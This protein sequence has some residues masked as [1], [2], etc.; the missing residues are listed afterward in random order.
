MNNSCNPA[1]RVVALIDMD[2]FY[3]QVE[4]QHNKSL[5]G[6]PVAVVQYNSW[7]GGGIIAVNYEARAKGVNRHMRGNDAV[8]VCPDLNL[9]RVKELHGKADLSKYRTAS[10]KVFEVLS[11]F[12]PCVQRASIDEAYI[13]LTSAINDHISSNQNVS[14]T[15][16]PNTF[17]EGYSDQSSNACRNE[18][19]QLWLNDVYNNELQ[20]SYLLNLTIGAVMI[21]KLRDLIFKKTGFC[22]SAGISN[23]KILA[24]LACGLHKPNQ[25]TILPPFS[26]CNLFKTIPIKKVKNLGGKLGN[27]VKKEFKCEFMSELAAIPLID[28]QKKFDNK[29]CNFLFQISRGIDNEPVE[30]RLINKSIGSCKAFP[31]GLKDKD[32]IQHWLSTLINDITEKLEVDYKIN[33]R[34]ATLIKVN[35]KYS[36]KDTN[37]A[38][39]QCGEVTTYN[40]KKLFDS[41]Y[42]MLCTMSENQQKSLTWKNPVSFIGVAIGKFI[43]VEVKSSIDKYFNKE[44][45][46]EENNSNLQENV[47]VDSK[48]NETPRNE[49]CSISNEQLNSKYALFS[50]NHPKWVNC[51][52]SNKQKPNSSTCNTN[53]VKNIKIS[54]NEINAKKKSIQD[55]DSFFNRKLEIISPSKIVQNNNLEIQSPSKHQTDYNSVSKKCFEPHTTINIT[56]DNINDLCSK[57]NDIPTMLLCEKCN[58]TIDI[59]LYEEHIDH[60]VAIELSKSLNS[61]DLTKPANVKIPKELITQVNSGGKKRKNDSKTSGSN[62]KK[63]YRRISTYFK[64]I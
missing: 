56:D 3:C 9:V 19:M 29:T 11:E 4:V 44:I 18:C 6:K 47:S 27:K 48:I 10:Q 2:C 23:N 45:A 17:V 35:V 52:L 36:N 32:Q 37:L 57:D 12:S 63:Q 64:P 28:L 42:S 39:S 5:A 59:N 60:H 34:K 7:K 15:D 13:D 40:F 30:S 49:N 26:V 53:Y 61:S 50:S 33:N 21:E 22:C 16:L 58:K 46:K 20:D 14:V 24:K 43:D 41:A 54:K 25:Q 31:L 62:P 1:E 38:S 8:Q 55:T 51:D